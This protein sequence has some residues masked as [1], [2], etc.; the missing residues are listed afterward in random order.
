MPNVARLERNRPDAFVL[1]PMAIPVRNLH[2]VFNVLRAEDTLARYPSEVNVPGV[3]GLTVSFDK[4]SSSFKRYVRG[5]PFNPF[6]KISIFRYVDGQPQIRF[7]E[8]TAA[9]AM[10]RRARRRRQPDA[11][12]AFELLE[13]SD[14]VSNCKSMGSTARRCAGEV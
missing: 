1:R 7:V 13:V 6:H 11:D 4:A 14:D 9:E 3:G 5:G 2:P 10:S 8:R 12:P